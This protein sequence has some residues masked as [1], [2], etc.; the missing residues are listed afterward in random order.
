M[1]YKRKGLLWLSSRL[2]SERVGKARGQDGEAGDGVASTTK[3]QTEVDAFAQLS[4]FHTVQPRE[5]YPHQW[6]HQ[7]ILNAPQSEISSL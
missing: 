5:W 1:N 6:H 4:A 2:Q 3:K 7:S